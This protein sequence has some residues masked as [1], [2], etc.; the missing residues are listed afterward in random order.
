M[1]C[2]SSNLIFLNI[3]S[4]VTSCCV[5]DIKNCRYI[6]SYPYISFT[7]VSKTESQGT[8]DTGNDNMCFKQA[9]QVLC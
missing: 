8:V 4:I 2:Q 1:A 9:P 7:L 3:A 5:F 6:F